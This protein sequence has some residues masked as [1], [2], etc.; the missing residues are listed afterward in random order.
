MKTVPKSKILGYEKGFF[1][2]VIDPRNKRVVGVHMVAP[3]AADAI[4]EA[5]VAIRAG[6]TIDDLIDTIHVFPT[7]SEGIKYAA[8]AFYRNVSKMPCCLL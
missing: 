7:I 4:H 2:V 5:A 1:K 6:M 3:G 8:L